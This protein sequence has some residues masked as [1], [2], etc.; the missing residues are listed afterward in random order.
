MLEVSQACQF[1]LPDTRGH[2]VLVPDSR[3]VVSYIHDQWAS[4]QSD[5]TRWRTTFLCGLGTISAHWRRRMCRAKWTK[6]QTC[7]RGI[8][9]LQRNGQSTR[10]WFRKCGKSLAELENC[11]PIGG[12][13]FGNSIFTMHQVNKY[14]QISSY[15]STWDLP[16]VL[17]ALKGPLFEPLQS[18]RLRALLLETALLLALSSV[19]RVWNLQALSAKPACLA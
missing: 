13:R 15:N 2:H 9:S 17:R 18:S 7:C 6:E 3:S 16:T 4:S 10:S 1:F 11:W 19:K 14:H 5:S 12:Q 8:M